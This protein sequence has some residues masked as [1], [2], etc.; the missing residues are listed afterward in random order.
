MM[1]PL[2]GVRIVAVEQYGAG[3]FSTMQLADLGAEVVK[4]E[5][6][7]EGGDVGRLRAPPEGPA[8]R[9]RQPLLPGVQPQQAVDR[10]RPQ[11]GGRPGGAAPISCAPPTGCSNNL[12]GDRPAQLGLTWEALKAV[13]PAIVCVHLSAYGRDGPRAAWPG[14]DYLMQAEA[15]YLSVTGEP[16]APPARMGLSMV[17]LA[18][19]VQAALAMTAGILAARAERHGPGPRR[20]ALRRGHVQP[21]LPRL[22]VSDRGHRPG[23]RAALLAPEPHAL[24]TLPHGRRLAVRHVQQGEV[25]G[26]TGGRARP[27]AGMEGRPALPQTSPPASTNAGAGDGG[28]RR[29]AVRED[30]GGMAGGALQGRVPVAPVH[31][32]AS[33]HGC[34]LPRPKPRA[35]SGWTIPSGRRVGSVGPADPHGRSRRPPGP[36]RPWAP[37]RTMCWA[38]LGYSPG[39]VAAL[40]AAKII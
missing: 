35:I 36:R 15:G 27:E 21:R 3:P 26:R 11:A 7:A 13:N 39:E 18:T 16:G 24:A 6:I 2:E 9:G 20:L 31:D 30:D 25:L 17:D 28:A 23:P 29:G 14:Y 8:S 19:G 40:R 4:V 34:A 38:G 5:N 1:L 12:R 33:R 37:M 32:I 22:L 10:A